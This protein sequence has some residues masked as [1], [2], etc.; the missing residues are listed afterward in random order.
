M[1]GATRTKLTDLPADLLGEIANRVELP[2]HPLDGIAESVVPAVTRLIS[3]CKHFQT[4]DVK[5]ACLAKL[6]PQI[7][8]FKHDFRLGASS[9]YY[10]SQ[11]GGIP[12]VARI[13]LAR[14]M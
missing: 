13:S 4:P 3:S 12:C 2:P 9:V 8:M 10:P 7:D 11:Y 5:L 14:A 1:G 6:A